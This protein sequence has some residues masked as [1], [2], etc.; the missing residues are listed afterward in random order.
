[1]AHLDEFGSDDIDEMQDDA[2]TAALAD[3]LGA[4]ADVVTDGEQTRLDFNLSFY[5]FL[6]G[7]EAGGADGTRVRAAGARPAGAA[8]HQRQVRCRKGLGDG[9]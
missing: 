8:P 9:R 1:M 7:V 2:V 6:D 3:Q 5:G 4:G